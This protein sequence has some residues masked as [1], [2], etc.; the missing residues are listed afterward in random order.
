MMIHLLLFFLGALFT[1]KSHCSEIP[2]SISDFLH[3]SKENYLE[4]LEPAKNQPQKVHFVLG[5]ESG[6][7]D[8]I[9]SSIAFAY[10]LNCENSNQLYVP[11]MNFRK[12][13]MALRKDALYLF[14]LL[15]ISID[16]LLFLDDQVPLDQLFSHHS[17][18]IDLVDHN[19]LR[20]SQEHLS[21]TVE[22]IVDHHA[23]ENK[24]YPLI[25]KK[26]KLIGVVG[27]ATTL[28]SE[29]M[30]TN[31]HVTLTPKIATLLLAPILIDT[32]N[33]QSIEKTTAK[34][35]KT[36][37]ALQ[38]IASSIIPLNFYEKLLSAK[39]DI[40]DLTPAMLLSKD[41]KEYLDGKI[42]YGISSIPATICWGTEDEKTLHPVLEKFA[43]ERKL[44][45]L[46]LLMT[47]PDPLGPKRKVI[48]YSSSQ[49]L[50]K[51]SDSYIQAD[52]NLSKIL[53]P[54]SLPSTTKMSFYS[55][56][57]LFARKQLQPLLDFSHNPDI[58]KAFSE[59]N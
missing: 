31:K 4:V 22:R 38:Q 2:S 17:L 20:P 28:I 48:I 56:K 16:D 29:K 42:L 53:I 23:D 11:L 3:R 36:A 51:S 39:N 18:R 57:K 40:A 13:E 59:E 35:I 9:V 55:I 50:L 43:S 7:L 5:N 41:F 33:L 26:D 15:N 24:Y 27:S 19:L 8:S 21:N 1:L 30:L 49:N 54:E 58:V 14:D 44:S 6:D 52:V 47:N 10:L 25:S 37:N 45:F 32:M 12:E 34:D 46:I